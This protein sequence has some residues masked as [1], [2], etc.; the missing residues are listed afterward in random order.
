MHSHPPRSAPRSRRGLWHCP[1]DRN[2]YSYVLLSHVLMG[3]DEARDISRL[4]E[5][6]ARIRG[7]DILLKVLPREE[8]TAYAH[9]FRQKIESLQ[10]DYAALLEG[11]PEQDYLARLCDVYRSQ[12]GQPLLERRVRGPPSVAVLDL[13]IADVPEF[14]GA[15][16]TY[17]RETG[18]DHVGELVTWHH[19]GLLHAVG[20]N[21]H[22][23]SNVVRVLSSMGLHL[24]MDLD[25][26]RPDHR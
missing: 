21:A 11:A 15:T 1:S 25:Y 10:E 16:K 18:I 26:E 6:V 23:L 13:R 5:L 19:A 20:S 9:D 12:E 22:L 2:T 14:F 24:G 8:A 4:L 17:V 7:D 3:V